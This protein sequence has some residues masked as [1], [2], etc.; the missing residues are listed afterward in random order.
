MLCVILQNPAILQPQQ[1]ATVLS[2]MIGHNLGI[3]HDEEG[4]LQWI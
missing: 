1:L 4:K 2:H 3:K